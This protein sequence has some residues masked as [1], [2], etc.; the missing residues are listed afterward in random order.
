MIKSTIDT[1]IKLNKSTC[2]QQKLMQKPVDFFD[3]RIQEVAS[4]VK[5]STTRKVDRFLEDKKIILKATHAT[6][7]GEIKNGVNNLNASRSEKERIKNKFSETFIKG[8]E[9]NWNNKK[10]ETLKLL[11]KEQKIP[12]DPEKRNQGTYLVWRGLN[13]KQ[14]ITMIQNESAGNQRADIN[15]TAPPESAVLLQVGERESLP[16]FTTHPG[17]AEQFGT[18]GYIGLFAIKGRFLSPGSTV[19]EGWVT[20]KNAPAEL[21]LFKEGRCI[22]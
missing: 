1:Q 3:I 9:H 22:S 18:N 2:I 13:V 20:E 5:L 17:I 8:L 6:L 7:P 14:L 19:E 16:E 12:T 11:I 21:I 10:M 15:A 4:Q